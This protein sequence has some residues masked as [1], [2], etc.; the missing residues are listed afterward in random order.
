MSA[1]RCRCSA[2]ATVWTIETAFVTERQPPPK[3][4]S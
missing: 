2:E 3:D 1:V 4:L